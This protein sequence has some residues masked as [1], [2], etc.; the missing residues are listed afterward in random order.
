MYRDA[1]PPAPRR[2]VEAIATNLRG[3]QTRDRVAR[4]FLGKGDVT[5]LLI[6]VAL[7]GMF[8]LE[9]D[10]LTIG[11]ANLSNILVQSAIRGIAS[12]GQALIMMT[13]GI[14]LS[15]SGIVGLTL[16]I[17]GS[18]ITANPKFSL[19]GTPMSPILALPIMLAI[20]AAF[21]LANGYLV[22]RFRLPALLVT[23]GTWQI[24]LGLA[25]QVTGSG[26]VDQ[27][28]AAISLFGQGELFSVPVPIIVL[29]AVVG[30]T[31]FVLHHT[32][33]G[34]D[35]FAVGGNPRCAFISGVPIR[36]VRVAVFGI[37]G[38]F[39]GIGAIISMSHYA[40]STLAQSSGLELSTI[41]AVAIGGVSL[42]GGR[43]TIVGVLLGAVIIGIIDNGLGVM[44]AGPAY[45]GIAKGLIII[46][47]VMADS[48][49]QSSS[50]LA[51]GVQ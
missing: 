31:Y 28:P 7:V 35:I 49:S 51:A 4:L 3:V 2:G 21:G 23:L 5:R 17:G 20:A 26:F 8:A 27:L 1:L 10:G 40:S 30:V 12:C 33:F 16:M 34:A 38:L 32:P 36:R 42:S 18:L 43:G 22:A 45:Q 39:Y 25:F 24:C 47:V 9:T 37:A 44:G 14:D 46:F 29:F 13:A 6:L 41:A 15:V 50:G 19:L 11:P 48:F